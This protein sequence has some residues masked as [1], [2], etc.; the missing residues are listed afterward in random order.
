MEGGGGAHT[1][2]VVGPSLLAMRL[3]ILAGYT[4]LRS[5]RAHKGIV[6]YVGLLQYTE[7][8]TWSKEGMGWN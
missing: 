7:S 1:T 3:H 6:R 8:R 2:Q 4:S 5:H